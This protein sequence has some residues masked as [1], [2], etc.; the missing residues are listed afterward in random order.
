MRVIDK[1]NWV[2]VGV[3]FL[4]LAWLLKGLLFKD[5]DAEIKSKTELV[6]AGQSSS[7][8]I[9]QKRGVIAQKELAVI[10]EK[11]AIEEGELQSSDLAAQQIQ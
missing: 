2:A 1:N 7:N 8:I 4:I 5:T 6:K 10:K 11:K 3:L 9:T